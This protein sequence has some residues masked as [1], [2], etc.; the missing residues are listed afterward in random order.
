MIAGP[1]AGEPMGAGLAGQHR[2]EQRPGA[3][4][5]WR[6]DE[7]GPGP[8]VAFDLDGVLSDG[9][10]RRHYLSG[11]NP[12]WDA[13]LAGVGDDPLIEETAC[14][15]SLLDRSLAVVL[16]TGRPARVGRVT[17]EWLS[18]HQLRWDLMVMRLDGDYRPAAV[19]KEQAVRALRASGLDIKLYFE[20][21]RRTV[22]LLRTEGLPTMYVHSGYYD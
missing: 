15:L 5:I 10:A 12:D 18:G 7:P 6:G 13:F 2:A 1:V 19:F 22:E 14:L 21:D 4:W 3:L 8:A 20:D 17:L 9:S 11:S 16:L